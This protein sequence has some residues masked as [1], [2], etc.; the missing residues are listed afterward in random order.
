MSSYSSRGRFESLLEVQLLGMNISETLQEVDSSLVVC[1]ISYIWT[2]LIKSA[3]HSQKPLLLE[4]MMSG[5]STHKSDAAFQR[6][7]CVRATYRND[8]KTT[9]S[10]AHQIIT[11]YLSAQKI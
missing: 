3:G 7:L 11:N 6:L 8:D 9:D 2:T 10:V 1:A 5:V 4:S